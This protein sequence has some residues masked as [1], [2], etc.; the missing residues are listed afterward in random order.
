[1]WWDKLHTLRQVPYSEQRTPYIGAVETW[2]VFYAP[3]WNVWTLRCVLRTLQRDAHSKSFHHLYRGKMT[4]IIQSSWYIV[5]ITYIAMIR[6]QIPLYSSSPTPSHTRAHSHT[7]FLKLMNYRQKKNPLRSLRVRLPSALLVIHSFDYAG[8]VYTVPLNSN[9][10]V[11]QNHFLNIHVRKKVNAEIY[12]TFIACQFMTRLIK[13]DSYISL[14]VSSGFMRND[15]TA[16]YSHNHRHPYHVQ[17][18][19]RCSLQ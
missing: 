2:R 11:R 18:H 14:G 19:L 8:C 7:F 15:L 12:L 10:S 1:M 5:Y 9:S 6:T 4:S 16:P 3:V 17:R 13:S